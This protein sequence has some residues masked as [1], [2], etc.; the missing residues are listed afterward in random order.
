[1]LHGR[2]SP[3]AYLKQGDKTLAIENYKRSLDLNPQNDNARE[4]LKK[5]ELPIG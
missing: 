1:M 3:R 4:V 2:E 5:L